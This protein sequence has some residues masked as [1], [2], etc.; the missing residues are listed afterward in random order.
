MIND[1]TTRRQRMSKPSWKDFWKEW[2][3]IAETML[4][5]AL[6]ASFVWIAIIILFSL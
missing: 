1:K 6:L 3:E 5:G 4:I 2:I